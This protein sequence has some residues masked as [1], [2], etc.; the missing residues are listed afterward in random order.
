[1][2]NACVSDRGLV[3]GDGSIIAKTKIPFL[4]CLCISPETQKMQTSRS[5]H[6]SVEVS[7]TGRMAL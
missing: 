3:S 2:L 5:D 6:L 7:V 1:M 4:P